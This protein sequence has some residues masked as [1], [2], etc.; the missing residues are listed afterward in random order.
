MLAKM[1][2]SM[3]TVRPLG[4]TM[5]ELL[6][7]TAICAILLGIG[8]PSLRSWLLSQRV[9][10]TTGEIITDLRFAR[11][12]AISSNSMVAIAFKNDAGNGC[13]TVFRVPSSSLPELCDCSKGAGFACGTSSSYTELK[14]FSLPA[15]SDVSISGPQ[16][17][18]YRPGSMLIHSFDPNVNKGFRVRVIAG[19]EKE[20][21]VVTTPVLPRPTACA[22]AGSKISGYKPCP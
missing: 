7:V 4:L 8:I 18:L 9:I 5:I 2:K 17:E 21:N 15:G 22:P 6:V 12:D 16:V 3:A 20:L 19:P 13:Y 10:S 11:S 1:S 14:T